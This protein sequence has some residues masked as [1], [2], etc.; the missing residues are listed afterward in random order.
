MSDSEEVLCRRLEIELDKLVMP[1]VAA[2]H[3]QAAW[4][5]MVGV[6][7]VM[8]AQ[9]CPSCRGRLVA[10]IAS[11]VREAADIVSGENAAENGERF[12]CH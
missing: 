2:G 7:G 6:M 11:H 12:T 3:F 9:R 10:G 8:L 5:A 1:M 4:V